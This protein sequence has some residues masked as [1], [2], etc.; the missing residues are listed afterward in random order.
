[1]EPVKQRT[2][3]PDKS[4]EE[5]PLA[6]QRIMITRPRERAEELAAPLRAL[7]AETVELPTIAIE[8][9]ADWASL[10]AALQALP[11]YDWLI[12]T[13]A[14][15]VRKLLERMAARGLDKRSLAAARFCAIG[16]ATAAEL[17]RHSLRVD[18]MPDE[19][20]AEGV[21]R[22]FAEEPLDGKRILLPRARVARD[23]LPQELR[24]RGAQVDVV[25]AYRT[26]TPPHSRERARGIFTRERPTWIT[27][28][29]SST[30]EN[31]LRLLP[32]GQRDS[33]LQGIKV[34]SIGPITSRTLRA[35]GLSVDAEA[36]QHTIPALVAAIVQYCGQ[37]SP[38]DYSQE[39][40]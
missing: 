31:L 37:P 29:S 21:V 39:S 34:A 19:Y 24:R 1:M 9:P 5:R 12:F 23:I 17:R 14:N 30:V 40:R 33:Y 8:D 32:P 16:P 15:G 35:R 2:N 11:R 13:S 20:V 36:P 26:V 6:G 7:G 27:F 38:R 4:S 28:T 10:D 18:K 3:T 25:E 22:A